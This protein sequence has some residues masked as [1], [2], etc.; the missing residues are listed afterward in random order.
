[1]H[2]IHKRFQAN[3]LRRHLVGGPGFSKKSEKPPG[4]RQVF[5][6]SVIEQTSGSGKQL[7]TLS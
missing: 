4:L 2:V 5:D 3:G 7:N 6:V 1:M